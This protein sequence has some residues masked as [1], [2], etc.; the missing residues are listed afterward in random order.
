[1]GDFELV[2]VVSDDGTEV[3]ATPTTGD[4]KTRDAQMNAMSSGGL[5]LKVIQVPG[6]ERANMETK[7]KRKALPGRLPITPQLGQGARQWF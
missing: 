5:S 6:S 2:F 4:L 7:E 1:V 3:T